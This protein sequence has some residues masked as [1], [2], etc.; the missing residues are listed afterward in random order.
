[1]RSSFGVFT[2]LIVLISTGCRLN[3]RSLTQNEIVNSKANPIFRRDS[4]LY[5]GIVLGES[6]EL[7]MKG[8]SGYRD[9]IFE[10]ESITHSKY[11]VEI[12]YFRFSG[13][14][15]NG[16]FSL[17]LVDTNSLSNLHPMELR[18][19]R[20]KQ[21]NV[22]IPDMEFD[23]PFCWLEYKADTIFRKIFLGDPINNFMQYP[24]LQTFKRRFA[25]ASILDDVR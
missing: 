8:G 3:N 6:A 10:L 15:D 5:L 14:S 20:L 12:R 13:W 19:G 23:G 7:F 17:P 16:I 4:G 11:P 2:V 22:Y 18:N 24:D 9:S 25:I 21:T 1:M